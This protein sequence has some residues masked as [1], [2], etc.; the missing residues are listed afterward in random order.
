[1]PDN[2]GRSAEEIRRQL[3]VEREQLTGALSD[4]RE[5]VHA[6]RRIPMIIGG[7]LAAGLAAFAAV[8]AVRRLG[9]D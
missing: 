5:D 9:D 2:G 7:A 8:K 1:M 4:L 3:S 6:A